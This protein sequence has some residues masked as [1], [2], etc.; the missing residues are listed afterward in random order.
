MACGKQF[1]CSLDP[2]KDVLGVN[3]VPRVFSRSYGLLPLLLAD[4]PSILASWFW[5]AS[6]LLFSPCVLIS[7]PR[8]WCQES[9]N[10]W[11][12][13]GPLLTQE[14]DHILGQERWFNSNKHFLFFQKIQVQFPEPVTAVCKSNAT[15]SDTPF[16]LPWAPDAHVVGE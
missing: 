13:Q 4:F 11:W 3:V 6:W 2:I 15:G 10:T 7:I 5:T 16:W 14:C 8:I 12:R 1:L 9:R